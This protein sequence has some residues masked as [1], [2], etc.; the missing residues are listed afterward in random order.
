MLRSSIF[1]VVLQCLVV[2]SMLVSQFAA[3]ESPMAGKQKFFDSSQ[4]Y[5]GDYLI[6]VDDVIEVSVW[7]NPDLSVSV[8][9][10]PDGKISTPLVKDVMAAGKTPKELADI[11]TDQ[12]AKYIRDPQVSI[13]VTGLNSHEYVSR[14]R[15]TG[16]V[17]APASVPHRMGMTVLDII[18]AAGGVSEFASANR[19]TLYRRTPDGKTKSIRI[20]LDDIL[21]KG[22]LDTNVLLQP[23]DV[24]TVP[25]GIF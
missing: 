17:N 6:G 18:L 14:V 9:V 5:Q 20:K 7:R 4:F 8:P 15:V 13:I 23:G 1:K 19:T 2:V 21:K 16:A 12:L 22:K 10:R 25:E 24:L 11:V 3:A